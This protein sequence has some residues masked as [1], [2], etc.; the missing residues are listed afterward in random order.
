MRAC[1]TG[2]GRLYFLECDCEDRANAA[3]TKEGV[4][5]RRYGHL[6]TQG[7]RQLAVEGIVTGFNY[8]GSKAVSFCKP[9]TEGKHHQNPFPVDG[10]KRAEKPLELV[11]SDV[12]SKMNGKSFGGEYF[13]T[14]TDDKTRFSWVYLLKSKDEVFKHFREWKAMIENVLGS[15]L[16]VLR[17]DNGGEYIG[18]QFQEYLKSE[19]AYGAKDPTT[20]WGGRATQ[21]YIG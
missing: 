6:G 13:L 21:P 1:A 2:F 18:K 4:W 15:K 10:G 20:E 3:V 11:H 5:H 8:S 14:F 16:K 9:Y 19:G 12:C 7:L 17:S